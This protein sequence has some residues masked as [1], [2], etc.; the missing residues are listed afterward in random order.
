M[1]FVSN[2]FVIYDTNYREEITFRSAILS[3]DS[4]RIEDASRAHPSPLMV[5]ADPRNHSFPGLLTFSK[6]A[7]KS[8][9][10]PSG[11]EV[12]K[13]P[14]QGDHND[15]KFPW[16]ACPPTLG[17]NIDRCITL[18][19]AKNWKCPRKNIQLD[20]T[21]WPATKPDLFLAL[22]GHFCFR[23]KKIIS[24]PALP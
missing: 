22:K 15:A 10:P 6:M 2:I 3:M 4:H 5:L 19:P 17:L 9:S 18:W 11:K 24:G 16:V 23:D 20:W 12:F 8:N 7:T 21:S 13:V 1:Y 14:T